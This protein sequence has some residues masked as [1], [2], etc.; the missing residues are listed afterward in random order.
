MLKVGD[1]VKFPPALKYWWSKRI[2]LIDFV[3]RDGGWEHG[4][5]TY[6]ALVEPGKYVKFGDPKWPEVLSES[7]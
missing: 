5:I 7:R 6:R 3:G 2:G 4:P 1:L